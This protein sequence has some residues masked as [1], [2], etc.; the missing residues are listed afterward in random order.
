MNAAGAAIQADERRARR[1]AYREAGGSKR[2]PLKS[3]TTA[4]ER[5]ELRLAHAARIRAA[6]E[7]LRE[8]AG[9]A[10]W[11][12]A[13]ALNPQLTPLNAA[14]VALQSPGEIVG[15]AAQ[16]KRQGGRISK[17]TR[18]AGRITGR[19]F[20]PTAYFT[21]AQAGAADLDD[22]EPDLPPAEH[23][24]AAR[25][26]L[27]QLLDAGVKGAE[28]V[29]AIAPEIGHETAANDEKGGPAAS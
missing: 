7:E 9:F 8:P 29:A 6:V 11:V 12:E 21:A 5:R 19:N 14:L 13:V 1:D 24:E 2:R 27:L 17:G 10:A 16:W 23:V 4:D 25:R 3:F 15:T 28:A 22:F 20:W 26:V 18:A